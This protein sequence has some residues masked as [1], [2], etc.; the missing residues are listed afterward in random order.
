[1]KRLVLAAAAALACATAAPAQVVKDPK[2]PFILQWTP[3]QQRAWYPA[4]ETVYRVETI[5]RGGKVS[6]LPRAETQ[7]APEWTYDGKPYTVARYMADYRASGLLVL[8]D[9]KIV[10]ERYG[11]GRRPRDRWTSFSVAKSVTSLLVGAAI[12][13]GKI[14]SLND[15]IALYVPELKGSA[16]EG[17]SV[18]QLLMMSSGVAWNE[19][20]TDPNSDVAKAGFQP[21]PA[22][23]N[24]MVAYM[25]TRPREHPPGSRFHYNTGETDMVGVLVSHAVGMPLAKYASEKLWKPLGMERDGIWAVDAGG[26][27]RGGCCMSMTLRDYGR[28][29]Q[30][31]L[32]GGTAHGRKL[33]PLGYLEAATSPQIRNGAPPD[34]YGYFWWMRPD[35]FQAIGIY[36]QS[37]TVLPKEKLVIVTNAAWPDATG[38]ELSAARDAFIAAVKAAAS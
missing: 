14:R 30:F 35:G 27:E 3:A 36:G 20:Y 10:L 12:A 32:D 13:D 26:H 6:P 2:T 5:P 15:D 22:G 7:I 8:K 18:R 1:M 34:G 31:V 28:L 24:P 17:V 19:D 21:A 29:G 23:V 33:L 25:A 9:G 11:L 37:I 16:Y 38:R 4:I